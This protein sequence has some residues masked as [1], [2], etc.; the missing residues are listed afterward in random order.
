MTGHPIETPAEPTR[1]PRGIHRLLRRFKRSQSGATAVEFAIITTP[2]LM[3]L[4]GI[5]ETALMFWTSQAL[6]EGV[7]QASRT[8]LTGQSQTLYKSAVAG[9]NATAFKNA[10][11]ASAPGLVDCT[12][13]TIDVR[14]YASFATANTGTTASS[15]V[16]GG[17]LNTTGYGYTQPLPGQIV[18]V[19]A[20]LEYQLI[21]T[22]WTSALAN[23]GSGKRAIVASTTFRAEPFTVPA[24]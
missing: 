24:T 17:A 6:E 13:V 1:R 14:S 8:L 23:L 4:A 20:V 3:M 7:A 2:F 10:I 11:C 19:R 12:K 15:P 22:Q 9:A 16:S 21:F 18:V 5:L